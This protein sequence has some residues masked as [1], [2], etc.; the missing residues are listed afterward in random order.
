MMLAGFDAQ[1]EE[2]EIPEEEVPEEDVTAEDAPVQDE[3]ATA[4]D[5]PEEEAEE[6]AEEADEMLTEDEDLTEDADAAEEVIEDEML[7]RALDQ[8][9]F[10]T[11]EYTI[12]GVDVTIFRSED[13]TPKLMWY[14][15]N[16]CFDLWFSYNP[17]LTD[18]E[19]LDYYRSV[20]PMPDFTDHLTK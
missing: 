18:K 2:A 12:D 5:L 6:P 10:T 19:L 3:P 16:Y 9:V 8:K 7:G 13:G 15:D 20:Q 14:L 4:T 17:D 1:A 11:E